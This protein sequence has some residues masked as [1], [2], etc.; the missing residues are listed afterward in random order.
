MKVINILCHPPQDVLWE[1]TSPEE[2]IKRFPL[3]D[4]IKIDEYPYWIGFFRLDW[5]HKWGS[6]VKRL[7]PA[8]EM[9]CW[10]NYGNK[11][12][13]VYQKEVDGILHKVFPSSSIQI[14][15][16]GAI[17]R[18]YLL[19][20]ELKK[21]IEHNKVIIHFYGSHNPLITW[22]I[23][24][25]KT[26]HTPVILQNLGGWFSWFDW[27]YN[28]NPL[29]LIPYFFERRM[30][31]KVSLYLQASMVEEDFLNRNFPKLKCKFLLNGIDFNQFVPRPKNIA[32]KELGVAP[33]KKMIL[34][35]G[36]LT[37]VKNVNHL[38]NAFIKLKKN[39]DDLLLYL[40]GGYKDEKYYEF[41]KKAGAV[42]IE[43]TDDS[44]D[45]YFATA[46]VYVMPITNIMV[47]EF[48]GIGIAPLEAL[49][50][51]TPV[52]SENL[53]HCPG[54]L[55]EISQLGISKINYNSLDQH[56]LEILN[57]PSKYKNCRQVALK[58]FSIN[59]NTSQLLDIYKNLYSLHYGKI[60]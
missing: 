25:L 51:N 17:S 60:E 5:H 12:N 46:D 41:G 42:I 9:E 45:K 44:I 38:I 6:Y 40:V 15:K 35:V 50:M 54:T 24:N 53:K 4:F 1:Y 18:S 16:Y 37:D 52:I 11:I 47:K 23:N 57:N 39:N 32:K 21:E 43:R 8:I 2:Y 28:N 30:L 34:Y 19:L 48:G 49:A 14:K 56:I 7:A 20:R 26:R 29:K 55:D 13:K 22:I 59:D 33:N 31:N 10:R 27:E 58:Y 36:R 3:T